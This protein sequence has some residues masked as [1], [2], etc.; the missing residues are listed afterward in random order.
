MTPF[1]VSTF[2]DPMSYPLAPPRTDD[3]S[4]TLRAS[5]TPRQA[6]SAYAKVLL[7]AVSDMGEDGVLEQVLTILHW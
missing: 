4:Q 3:C 7:V 1:N 2:F 6:S 5:L